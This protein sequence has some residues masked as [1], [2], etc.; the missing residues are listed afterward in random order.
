M[1]SEYIY[2]LI[3]EILIFI[4]VLY[5]DYFKKIKILIITYTRLYTFEK[6]NSNKINFI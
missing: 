3:L 4:I 1:N 2:R 5:K 6:H